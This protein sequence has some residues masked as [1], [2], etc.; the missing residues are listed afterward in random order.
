MTSTMT[1]AI[2]LAALGA[3]ATG[4]AAVLYQTL[5]QQGRLLLRLDQIE[6]NLKLEAADSVARGAV[7]LQVRKLGGMPVGM[8]LPE[9]ALPG[10]DGE[11]VTLA[12]LAGRQVLLVHWS[13]RCGYC[14]QIAPELARLK[15]EL[16]RAGALLRLV[17]IAGEERERELAEAHGL[18]GELL[19]DAAGDAIEAFAAVGTP[20]A[21]RLDASGRI[22]SPLVVGADRVLELAA[23][24][25]QPE[26]V[27]PSF[28]RRELAAS[29]IER[30]GLGAGTPAP[31]FVLPDVRGGTVAL[32]GFR[33]RKVLLVFSDPHCGP[34]QE[35]APHLARIDEAH[36]GNGLAVVLVGRGEPEENRAKADA[37]GLACPL[38]VQRGWELSKRYGIFATPV[39]FLIDER[40]VVERDV[41]RGIEEILSLVPAAALPQ[42]VAHGRAVR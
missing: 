12:R 38:V 36:R 22:A 27:R 19:L 15:P 42:E 8:A 6:R 20:A 33:G 29:R 32:D 7:A 37:Q 9:L 21:Y 34:C 13:A 35:L 2:G 41:A 23:E 28:G 3:F 39:G 30:N 1:L 40:G 24:L 14:A 5:Q 26:W 10:L 31:S 16:E 4:L 25:A 11:E 17:G 18:A